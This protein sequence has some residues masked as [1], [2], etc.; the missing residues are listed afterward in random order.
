MGRKDG[1]L[2]NV[3][4]WAAGSKSEAVLGSCPSPPHLGLHREKSEHGSRLT[5]S[6][7]IANNTTRGLFL[8]FLLEAE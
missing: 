2:R 4:L 1:E 6:N 8:P 7:I 5:A 3:R